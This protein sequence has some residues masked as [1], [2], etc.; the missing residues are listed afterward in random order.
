MLISQSFV[1]KHKISSLSGNCHN[2]NYNINSTV[3]LATAKL[4]DVEVDLEDYD[5]L[6]EEQDLP[7]YY[8][9]GEDGNELIFYG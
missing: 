5:Y 9:G 3:K 8:W 2:P 1:K 6:Y 7:K 4:N